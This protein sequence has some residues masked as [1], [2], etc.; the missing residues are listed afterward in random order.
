MLLR[1]FSLGGGKK[2]KGNLRF[3][4]SKL[5]E[6]SRFWMVRSFWDGLFREGYKIWR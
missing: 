6:S 5:V 3:A 2:K 4:V 1:G